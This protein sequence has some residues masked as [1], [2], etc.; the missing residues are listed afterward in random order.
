MTKPAFVKSIALIGFAAF[1]SFALAQYTGP[2]NREPRPLPVLKTVAEVLSKPVDDQP[3]ELTGALVR[4]TGSE[5]FQFRDAT[6]EIRVEIDRDDFPAGQPIGETTRVK[7]VGEVETHA[8]RAPE[9]DVE[10]VSVISAEPQVE[11]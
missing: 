10:Q 2:G 7:L 3:V 8:L 1:S 4:Q 6:G 5:T 9:I 11:R